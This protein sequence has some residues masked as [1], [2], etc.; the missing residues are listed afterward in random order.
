[1]ETQLVILRKYI[2]FM[3]K[4]GP[5]IAVIGK[6]TCKERFTVQYYI[7]KKNGRHLKRITIVCVKQYQIGNLSSFI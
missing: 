2:Q 7:L 6:T 4:E 3:I 1:M 5:T